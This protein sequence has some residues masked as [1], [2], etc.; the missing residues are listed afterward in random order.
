MLLGLQPTAVC[1]LLLRCQRSCRGLEVLRAAVLLLFGFLSAS[2]P[3]QPWS[4]QM[5]ICTEIR[6]VGGLEELVTSVW[7]FAFC[8]NSWADLPEAGRLSGRLRGFSL[9]LSSFRCLWVRNTLVS[10]ASRFGG[11]VSSQ[12]SPPPKHYVVVQLFAHPSF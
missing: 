4:F 1:W 12:N 9:R 6:L 11:D 3:L 2:F 5:L 8:W 7:L 10:C